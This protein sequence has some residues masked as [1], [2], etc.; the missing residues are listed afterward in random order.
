MKGQGR[1]LFKS[2]HRTAIGRGSRCEGKGEG[3]VRPGEAA[4]EV[5]T[6]LLLRSLV[7]AT[8]V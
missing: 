5:S 2:A 8:F 3:R 1:E 7:S 4:K 6:L